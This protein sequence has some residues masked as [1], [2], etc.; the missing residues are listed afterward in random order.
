[1]KSKAIKRM[2]ARERQALYDALTIEQKFRLIAS[3]PGKSAKEFERLLK[4]GN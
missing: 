4:K 3:R 2:E 1:M